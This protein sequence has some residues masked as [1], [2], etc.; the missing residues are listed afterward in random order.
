[1]VL[2]VLKEQNHVAKLSKCKFVLEE[3]DYLEHIITME[4]F[5][6]D[7]S[8]ILSMLEWPIPKSIKAIR[9][10]FGLNGYYQKFIRNYGVIAAPF[11]DLLK[12]NAFEWSDKATRAF[13]KLKKAIP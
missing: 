6:A 2:E 3:I 10:C 11:T 8:K 13:E 12:N 4:G 9:G 5:K 1:M 7:S